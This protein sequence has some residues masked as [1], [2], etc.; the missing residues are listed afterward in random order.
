MHGESGY[1]KEERSMR[2]SCS[3]RPKN[4]R[5]GA[6]KRDYI[7]SLDD[8]AALGL[9]FRRLDRQEAVAFAAILA[10]AGIFSRF[11][12]ALTLAAVDAGTMHRIV[13]AH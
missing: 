13:G 6:F 9:A 5:R 12:S 3:R 11:A 8:F 10:F 1:L 4:S 2:Q 7:A